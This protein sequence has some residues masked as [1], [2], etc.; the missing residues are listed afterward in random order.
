MPYVSKLFKALFLELLVGWSIDK[1]RQSLMQP[2]HH[3]VHVESLIMVMFCFQEHC[4][5]WAK[6]ILNPQPS[7]RTLQW[8]DA[9]K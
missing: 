4:T 9:A 3:S 5:A 8:L 7:H 1:L 2:K 6:E